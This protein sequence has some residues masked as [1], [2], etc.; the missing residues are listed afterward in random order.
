MEQLRLAQNILILQALNKIPASPSENSLDQYASAQACSPARVL[1]LVH[2]RRLVE[3]LAYW[4][5]SSDDP[6]K[7]I[8]LCIEEKNDGQ[9]MV[10][11]LAVNHGNLDG[12]E[13][14]FNAMK[15]TLED[16]ATTHTLQLEQSAGILRRQIVNLNQD[17][18]L[19]R[20]GSRHAKLKCQHKKRKEAR[21]KL[22]P[23][24]ME[25]SEQIMLG[26]S[27]L[28]AQTRQDF[29]DRVKAIYQIFLTLETMSGIQAEANEGIDVLLLLIQHVYDIATDFPLEE[30][31]RSLP[32]IDP[33]GVFRICRDISKLSRY[34]TVP[35]ELV[36]AAF[37]YTVLHRSR[38]RLPSIRRTP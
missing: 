30:V 9:A 38:W 10:I 29:H 15:L 26:S 35:Q 24:M 3:I 32:S 18:I 7:V 13:A 21:R 25:L 11:R 34:F 23:W 37:R 36:Q 22:A 19:F 16:V 31:L 6:R 4:A 5:S 27:P 1:S 33:Q 14:A 2:E 28:T 17:R 12:I 20:L 8:A